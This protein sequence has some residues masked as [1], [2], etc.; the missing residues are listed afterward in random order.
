MTPKQTSIGTEVRFTLIAG[1]EVTERSLTPFRP[2]ANTTIAQ[3]RIIPIA[4]VAMPRP[5]W[6]QLWWTVHC[7]GRPD[8][9]TSLL[10]TVCK[11]E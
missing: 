9:E 11:R 4:L 7:N 3:S 2:D 10:S 1:T 8:K 5:I 6:L